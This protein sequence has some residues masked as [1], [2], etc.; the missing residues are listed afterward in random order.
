MSLPRTQAEL[1]MP[2][3]WSSS[4]GNLTEE[5]GTER[6]RQEEGEMEKEKDREEGGRTR[7]PGPGGLEEPQTSVPLSPGRSPRPGLQPQ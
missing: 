5:W 4:C 7:C 6:E 3:A 2:P 1:L